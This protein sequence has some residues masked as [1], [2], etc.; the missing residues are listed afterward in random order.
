MFC[1]SASELAVTWRRHGTHTILVLNAIFLSP[2][3]YFCLLQCNIGWLLEMLTLQPDLHFKECSMWMAQLWS[4]KFCIVSMELMISRKWN[5]SIRASNLC[6]IWRD[7]WCVIVEALIYL[8]TST[9]AV[10]LYPEVPINI[11][12]IA[13]TY[14]LLKENTNECPETSRIWQKYATANSRC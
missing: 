4:P 13:G 3:L 14:F 10:T 6:S 11:S 12:V 9:S 8:I 2:F 5:C 1:A 7:N